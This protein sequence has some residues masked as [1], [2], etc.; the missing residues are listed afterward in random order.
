[1]ST[2]HSDWIPNF[3]TAQSPMGL[4]RMMLLN[5]AKNNTQFKYFDI[6][7]ATVNGKV[8]WIAWYYTDKVNVDEMEA[9]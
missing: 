9:E 7:Q 3:I 2:I 8:V 4:R 6:A 5:N 1:V